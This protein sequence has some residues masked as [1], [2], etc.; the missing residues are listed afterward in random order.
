MDLNQKVAAGIKE[1]MRNKDEARKRTLRAIK[2]QILLFKTDG[3]GNELTPDLEIKMIQKMVKERQDSYDVYIK[4]NRE[5]L[6]SVEKEEIDILKEYLPAQMDVAELRENILTIIQQVGADS[7]K[8]M[9]KV[10]GIASKKFAGVSDG[11][12]IS[13]IVRELLSN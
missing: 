12:T 9:G 1:A 8:D 3:K 11:K 2:S 10:M 13:T 4:Q 6:A 5:D 7:M